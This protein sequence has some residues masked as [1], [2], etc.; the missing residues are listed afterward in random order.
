M[1]TRSRSAP[2]R[3]PPTAP[4]SASAR[5]PAR[6]SRRL[7]PDPLPQLF[8]VELAHAGQRHHRDDRDLPRVLV[9]GQVPLGVLGE[10]GGRRLR[11]RPQ[12]HDPAHL[13]PHPP[14]PPP[15]PPALRPRRAGPH[16]SLT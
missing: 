6:S 16:P 15:H 7:A 10:L 4:G 9:G 2:P 8:A 5:S 11:A 12:R 1:A 13:L 14:P 3:P